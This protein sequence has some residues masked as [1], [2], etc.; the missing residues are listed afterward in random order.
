MNGM[1][2]Q[3]IF[4]ILRQNRARLRSFGVKRIGLF[5]SFVRG[6]Q[7]QDS[8]VDLLVEF[9]PGQKTFDHFMQLSF[10]LDDVLGRRV[11]VVTVESLSPYMAAHILNEVEDAALV[12]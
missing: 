8:D 2:K 5:G 9:E 11:E 3:D 1:T 4:R 12:A 7:R 6:Q 10:Y